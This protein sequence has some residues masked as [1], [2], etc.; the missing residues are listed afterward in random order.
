[1]VQLSRPTSEARP[2]A[3]S[4]EYFVFRFV[5]KGMASDETPFGFVGDREVFVACPRDHAWKWWA[6]TDHFGPP[7]NLLTHTPLN[8]RW[9]E[10]WVRVPQ[11]A[12]VWVDDP[13]FTPQ[14]CAWVPVDEAASW[15]QLNQ[16]A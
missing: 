9:N 16:A 6:D 3:P 7:H 14:V 5:S 4:E 10:L 8:R 2:E 12:L 1:M 13:R 15:G 11:G